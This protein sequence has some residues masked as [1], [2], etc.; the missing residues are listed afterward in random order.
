MV[1]DLSL[2]FIHNY[3][4]LTKNLYI[5]SYSDF[6]K[7]MYE[8]FVHSEINRFP[9]KYSS[10]EISDLI[11]TEEHQKEMEDNFKEFEKD[12]LFKIVS[13]QL[14]ICSSF[15]PDI[16][17]DSHRKVIRVGNLSK[18]KVLLLALFKKQEDEFNI[19]LESEKCLFKF[20][21]ERTLDSNSETLTFKEDNDIH[22]ITDTIIEQMRYGYACKMNIRGLGFHSAL[23]TYSL[24]KDQF[25]PPSLTEEGYKYE[26]KREIL[27]TCAEYEITKD[28]SVLLHD[29]VMDGDY[30]EKFTVYLMRK[31]K[32]FYYNIHYKNSVVAW[33]DADGLE[34]GSEVFNW[35]N[36]L[37]RL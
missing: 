6:Q 34:T 4:E 24:Y 20:K 2:K 14:M 13:E 7:V 17:T 31:E 8:Y 32:G 15:Y 22:L 26:V 29:V 5:C 21:L 27:V 25:P 9:Y 23:L 12:P 28:K 36:K 10:E 3:K 19:Y 16:P 30:L 35:K 1:N 18:F 33:G 37:V 11:F